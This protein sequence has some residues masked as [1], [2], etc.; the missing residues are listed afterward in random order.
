MLIEEKCAVVHIMPVGRKT[1][2][3]GLMSHGPGDA[4]AGQI[5]RRGRLLDTECFE[6]GVIG[7][8]GLFYD[9]L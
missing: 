4:F 1:A 6:K 9:L 3:I 5:K 7:V 2:A 8:C